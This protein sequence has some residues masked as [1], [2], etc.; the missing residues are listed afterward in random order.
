MR[1]M[2]RTKIHRVDARNQVTRIK[3]DVSV[4]VR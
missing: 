1:T 4:G 3:R 2:L